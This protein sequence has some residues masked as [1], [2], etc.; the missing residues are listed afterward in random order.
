MGRHL[1]DLGLQP[2]PEFGRILDACYEAQLDGVFQSL[3]EGIAFA[4]R[5]Q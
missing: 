4:R 5:I 1:I 2:S 3:A